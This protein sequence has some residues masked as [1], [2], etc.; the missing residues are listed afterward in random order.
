[1]KHSTALLHLK[2]LWLTLPLALY[3]IGCVEVAP[4][5]DAVISCNPDAES[6]E[7]PSGWTCK[8]DA[9]GTSLCVDTSGTNADVDPPELSGT[10]L[11]TPA[12]GTDGT[13]FTVCFS[14]SESLSSDPVVNLNAGAGLIVLE[15]T[16]ESIPEAC[17]EHD[18]TYAWTA[19]AD[20]AAAGTHPLTVTLFDEALNKAD[21][22]SLGTLSLDFGAPVLSSHNLSAS[23]A[24]TGQEVTLALNFN[25]AIE[26]QPQ[27]TMATGGGVQ[28]AW[29][30]L[31]ATDEQSFVFV[32]TPSGAEFEGVYLI[33]VA[34][35]DPAGNSH[36]STLSSF[37][38]LDFDA[39]V[40]AAP[41]I[42]PSTLVG[43][44]D[45][46]EV[47]FPTMGE[48]F[49]DFPILIVVGN[50]EGVTA[51]VF[52]PAIV[53]GADLLFT[54][55][56][57]S[58][59]CAG[60]DRLWGLE[61]GQG[62][63]LAGNQMMTQTFADAL[64][65]DC[66]APEVVTSCLNQPGSE[67]AE[68]GPFDADSPPVGPFMKGETARADFVV[69][70]SLAG[71]SAQLGASEVPDCASL[72]PED[73]DGCCAYDDAEKSLS[74]Y[75]P[76]EN[77][78]YHGIQEWRL[79]LEDAS[80]NISLLN[81]NTLGTVEVD[82]F[83]P[84]LLTTMTPCCQV[85]RGDTLRFAINSNECVDTAP[86][87]GQGAPS[88]I[89]GLPFTLV[90][91]SLPCSDTSAKEL[92]WE[93]V[94]ADDPDDTHGHNSPSG[95]YQ[96]AVTL[97]DVAGNT[98]EAY[99]VTFTID[100]SVPQIENL[101]S[102]RPVYSAVADGEPPFNQ[103]QVSFTLQDP[104]CSYETPDG[105][106][107]AYAHVDG[108]TYDCAAHS[109]LE[110]TMGQDTLE[111]E[112]TDLESGAYR[113][114]TNLMENGTDG[115]VNITVTAEDRSGN[116]TQASKSVQL[117]FTPP[118]V[119]STQ[120]I[121]RPAQNNL[122]NDVPRMK[123]G[124]TAEV[125]FVASEI[126]SIHTSVPDGDM[127]VWAACGA[128][129]NLPFE[130]IGDSSEVILFRYEYTLADTNGGI[131]DN[132][133]INCPVYVASLEDQVGNRS[134][135][136][137]LQEVEVD[138]KTP[139]I[140]VI[141]ESALKHLRAPWG[142][143]QTD[144]LPSQ[145]IVGSAV[146]SSAT[147]HDD[148][149][150]VPQSAL[151]TTEAGV[152]V[153]YAQETGGNS[154][155]VIY[156]GEASLALSQEDNREVWLSAV[157]LS[158]NESTARVRVPAVEWVATMGNKVLGS[159]LENPHSLG[160]S[161]VA[162]DGF[163][164]PFI[165]ESE[166]SAVATLGAGALVERSERRWQRVLFKRPSPRYG[167]ALV[168]DATLSKTVLF[169]GYDTT[170]ACTGGESYYCGDT[171]AFDGTAWEKI[172]E[173]DSTG[174]TAPMPRDYHAMAY[175][176][177]SGKTVLFGGVGSDRFGDTWT[178]DGTA[179]EKI[180]DEDLSGV[181]APTP[182]SEH[183][184]IYDATLGKT[185]LFGGFDIAKVCTGG[186]SYYCGDT[187][188][189]DGT[190]WE[191]IL[192]EDRSGVTAPT[193]RYQHAMAYDATLGK[194]V[195]F[196]GYVDVGDEG[197]PCG[198]G[199]LAE[200]MGFCRYGDTWVFDGNGWEKILDEDLSG[201]TAPSP[202]S[203]PSLVYDATLGKTVLFGGRDSTYE[204]QGDTWIFDGNGW[205]KI[206]GEDSDGVFAPS[207]RYD[208]A[209][210]YDA[211][212]GKTVFFGGYDS[213][214]VCSGGV[215]IYCGDTWTFDGNTW[216]KDD[217]DGIV[218]PSRR[219][220]HAMVDDATLGKTVLF[221]GYN[222]GDTWTFDG[223]AWEKILDADLSGV[224]T[225]GLR[226]WYAMA[227]DATLGKTVLF[228]GRTSLQDLGDTWAFD[229]DGWEKILDENPS[230]TLVPSP[231]HLHAM[232]YDATLGKTVLFGGTAQVGSAGNPEPSPC[233]Y[234]NLTDEYGY[235][236]YGNTWAFDGTAWEKILDTD[237][238]GVS[239]P[240]PRHSHAM[241]FDASLGKTVLFGGYADVGNEGDPC[242]DGNV[243]VL[244]GRCYYGDTWVFD[245]SGWEKILDKDSAGV[246]APHPRT[247]HAMIYDASLGKTVLFGGTDQSRACRS[248]VSARCG[249]TWV[250]DG[251]AWE[252]IL[253]TDSTGTAAPKPRYAH[254]MVYNANVGKTVLF[255]GSGDNSTFND[256]WSLPNIQNHT[257]EKR[258][259]VS[260]DVAQGAEPRDCFSL[261]EECL[262]DAV[263]IRAAAGGTGGEA[264]ETGAS[265]AVWTG[266]TYETLD[267]NTAAAGVDEAAFFA[268]S[269][270]S[271]TLSATIDDPS[272]LPRIFIGNDRTVNVQLTVKDPD[273]N[274][275]TSKL[276]TDYMEVRVRY[277]HP[278][279]EDSSEADGG[280]VDGGLADGGL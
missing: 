239:A 76:L 229:G 216:E 211:T 214:K 205:E 245:G 151:D 241:V 227:Y 81:G 150:I 147:I 162:P 155:G 213:S 26:G 267:T 68:C 149:F 119:T 25:E 145:Y 190:A 234:G 1:M 106:S 124:T 74:C 168:Y 133:E 244:H 93:Y 225:P 36:L 10:P 62:R 77:G 86:Y 183:T 171:W 144:G 52:N 78:S 53:D 95:V 82:L 152:M 201:V 275:N 228:G 177:T 50:T 7:C 176:A 65:V 8:E 141:H 264:Q 199:N 170:S 238:S 67:D 258:M 137:P 132:A 259:G 35:E 219:S 11:I 172:L 17:V 257:P 63:D 32:Y 16:Q 248:G 56:V 256:T 127:A 117:D 195:L 112:A 254:A 198:D 192:D 116:I 222:K 111:C 185:V 215:G 249:D 161:K 5:D 88:P 189:F 180:L 246:L 191:K 173:A 30:Q 157:D 18:Y 64:R 158:G 174:T 220:Q 209:M 96:S 153:A 49:A 268:Q 134:E 94:V 61:L 51:P 85:K 12:L 128:E 272:L 218:T 186:E 160:V 33:T 138:T 236:Y 37:F 14:A 206:L 58:A 39:P 269:E 243:A 178:F 265:L 250:F 130:A 42:F 154:L 142:A 232:V 114:V 41:T 44:G 20:K 226:E 242:G 97:A 110:A 108:G 54:T 28:L 187:W 210:I 60:T 237:P 260:F 196:G 135:Q 19:S 247:S 165:T 99:S 181:T 197:D 208:Q 159:T 143:A 200:F 38:T 13:R 274:P 104:S 48:T 80:G 92:I 140:S 207:P 203:R 105:G 184:M 261:A 120:T 188:A 73:M 118:T 91:T 263:E 166:G 179:W 270:E 6:N 71:F 262:L 221:G 90:S 252:K 136:L 9:E 83:P 279:P 15:P 70:E 278:D 113:C 273:G 29:S 47:T 202:R 193:P 21:G 27:V 167:H 57:R 22:L 2:P 121:Y 204:T 101:E 23:V 240:S 139:D 69:N 31:S 122:W 276:T 224:T 217:S 163:F 126:S 175:D 233:P 98:S 231:R 266:L 235:C 223:T 55:V 277:R 169:G 103:V 45:L 253:E 255:G 75:Q 125:A 251:S 100:N 89:P 34:A 271:R 109:L 115:P 156:P 43:P 212:L 72:P 280:T 146:P 66:Q 24:S 107:L 164:N 59:D 40:L 148:A 123:V 194:T 79:T 230:G 102:A 87:A 3:A 131:L 182:R 84:E 4:P 129:A 46:V